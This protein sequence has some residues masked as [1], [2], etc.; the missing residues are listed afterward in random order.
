MAVYEATKRSLA[1][2]ISDIKLR[3]MPCGVVS[4]EGYRINGEGYSYSI[5]AH[6]FPDCKLEVTAWQRSGS[7]VDMDKCEF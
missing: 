5:S 7:R 3:F 4:T 1:E 6:E 2:Y